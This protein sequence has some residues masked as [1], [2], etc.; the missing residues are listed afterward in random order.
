ML[1]FVLFKYLNE[2]NFSLSEK[3][4]TGNLDVDLI[5]RQN[6][7][8]LLAWFMRIKCINPRLRQDE[9]A[10]QLGYSSSSLLPYRH[11]LNMFHHT[12][13]H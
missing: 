9:T 8:D 4:K 11:E 7:L 2:Y 5:L 6:K 1:I 3:S 13:V 10:R 12:E